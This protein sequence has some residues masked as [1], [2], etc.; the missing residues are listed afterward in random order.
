MGTSEN[1][2]RLISAAFCAD[3]SEQRM[4]V[5]T[6]R[7][8][9]APSRWNLGNRSIFIVAKKWENCFQQAPMERREMPDSGTA[10]GKDAEDIEP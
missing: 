7:Q 8:V 1:K 2:S 5:G 6:D 4:Q 3:E 10:G 9:N